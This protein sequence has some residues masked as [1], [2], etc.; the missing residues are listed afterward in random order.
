MTSRF[1]WFF[2]LA[3]LALVAVHLGVTASEASAD[4]T[5]AFVDGTLVCTGAAVGDT[6]TIDGVTYTKRDRDGV[7]A[8]R[9]E[10]AR[11][12]TSGIT[13]MA[14][15]FSGASTFNQDISSWDTS[16]ATSMRFMFSG[17]SAFNQD[18]SRW[19]TSNVTTME[20]M[21]FNASAFNQFIGSWDTSNVTDMR[22]MF[23]GA[24]AFNQDIGGWETSKVANMRSMFGGASAFNQN[25]NSWNTSNVVSMSFMFGVASAFNQNIN[26]WNTSSVTDMGSMFRLASAFNQNIGGW[27]TSSVTHMRSMFLDAF[28][29]NQDIGGWDTSNVTDMREMFAGAS[30]FNQNI[31]GWN[32]SNVTS[33]TLMF[34]SASAFNQ[35]IGG[36]DTSNVMNMQDMFR[37]AAA[38]DQDIGG[39]SL[40]SN[41]DLRTMLDDAGLSVACYDA[42]LIGWAEGSPDVIDRTLGASSLKRSGASDAARGVLAGRGWTINDAGADGKVT[43]PCVKPVVTPTP[44]QASGPSLACLPAVL[45]VGQRVSCTVSGADAGIEILWRAAYNPVFA[46]AGMRIGANGTGTLTFTIPAAAVGSEL[47]VELVEWMAPMSL[48]VVGGPVPRS[49]PAGDGPGGLLAAVRS[50]IVGLMTVALMIAP[51]LLVRRSDSPTRRLFHGLPGA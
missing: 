4:G 29:F 41:V 33:M 51:I 35:N 21:F 38:F 43:G 31:G 26:S 45:T 19:N 16:T 20:D 39:W 13:N 44:T 32:T 7:I 15:L 6:A 50:P 9:E 14:S 37:R 36:W 34:G 42:T 3:V 25:I 8:N 17:A 2:G 22:F 49:V 10:A 30:A 5:F 18:I 23:S 40:N 11:T 48:G 24:S 47:S 12:C 46:S 28:A 27:N 1:G